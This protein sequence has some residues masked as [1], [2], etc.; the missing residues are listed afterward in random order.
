M[1]SDVDARVEGHQLVDYPADR[2]LLVE[3]GND[4]DALHPRYRSPISSSSR[5][6]RWR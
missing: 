1:T 2:V 5:R 3:R 4:R 6:A